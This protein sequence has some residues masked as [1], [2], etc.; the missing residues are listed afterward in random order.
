MTKILFAHPDE[1]LSSIYARHIQPHFPVES[2]HDGLSALRK[3]RLIR[4]NLVISE[5]YLPL[6]SGTSLLRFMRSRPEYHMIPFI[7][8]SD[9]HDN[10]LAL[11]LGA[12]DWLEQRFSR[13]E[14]LLEKIYLH[15]KLNKHAIQ[16]N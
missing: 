7:F 5:Y 13:P 2:A 4:P 8:L 3:L 15:L 6:L 14:L 12:N 10:S 1:K 9:H 16:I 11:G